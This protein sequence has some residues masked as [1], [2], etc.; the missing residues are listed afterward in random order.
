MTDEIPPQKPS[1]DQA[2][3]FIDRISKNAEASHNSVPTRLDLHNEV[4]EDVGG[5]LMRDVVTGEFALAEKDFNIYCCELIESITYAIQMLKRSDK[6]SVSSHEFLGYFAEHI[7]ECCN[8]LRVADAPAIVDGLQQV[9]LA[10]CAVTPDDDDERV[11]A[12]MYNMVPTSVWER[13]GVRD[14][15]FKLVNLIREVRLHEE[16]L[17]VPGYEKVFDLLTLWLEGIPVPTCA[18]VALLREHGGKWPDTRLLDIYTNEQR[19]ADPKITALMACSQP[20]VSWGFP[21]YSSRDF[22]VF[23]R[24][25]QDNKA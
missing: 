21:A 3:Q 7:R 23:Y 12:Y 11:R 1:S 25:Q 8:Y 15:M 2:K 4:Y 17:S 18:L 9:C 5:G 20:D 10:W 14:H 24:Y 19:P 16:E 6:P 13:S 22:T